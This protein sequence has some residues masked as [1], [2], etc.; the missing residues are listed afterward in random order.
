M[1]ELYHALYSTCSQKVRFCLAEKGL[2]WTDRH[3]DLF[4]DHQLKP[5]Y[6]ALNPDG[7][8]PTLVHD[9]RPVTESSVICEYLDDVFPDT[10]RSPADAYG[11]AVMRSWMAFIAEIPTSFI[12]VVTLHLVFKTRQSVISEEEYAANTERRPV[13]KYIF[14]KMGSNGFPES[15]I[16]SAFDGLRQTAER[17]DKRLEKGRWIMGDELTLADMMLVP[18][19]DRMEDL[20]LEAVW[21]DLSRFSDWWER[22]KQRPAYGATYPPAARFSYY[23]PDVRDCAGDV[24][25]SMLSRWGR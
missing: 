21:A 25:K 5:E 23:G 3:I 13:R 11:K 24:Y 17:V 19:I 9:G 22:I 14:R 7:V 18:T 1:L 2:E 4:S 15:D 12:R 8:V 20:S 16:R 6:L 10:S